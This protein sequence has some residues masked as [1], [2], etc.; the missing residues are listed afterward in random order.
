MPSPYDPNEVRVPPLQR[1][2]TG[3]QTIPQLLNGNEAFTLLAEIKEKYSAIRSLVH[4][5][6]QANAEIREH[7]RVVIQAKLWEYSNLVSKMYWSL[8]EA[9]GDIDTI[10]YGME[11]H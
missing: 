2:P 8:L 3:I 6:E 5:Y 4:D 1:V 9:H 11:N 7:F 10:L